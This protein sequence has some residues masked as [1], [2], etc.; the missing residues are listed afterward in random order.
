MRYEVITSPNNPRL[1]RA[2]SLREAKHR[3]REGLILIDGPGLIDRALMAGIDCQELYVNQNWVEGLDPHGL[4]R[5]QTWLDA[6]PDMHIV[7][8][9]PAAMAKLRYGDREDDAIAV[10]VPPDTSLSAASQRMDSERPQL[11]LVLDRMEKPGNLGAMVRSADASGATAV[12]I[13]DPICELWNPNAIRSSLGTLF[14]IPIAVGSESELFG[15]LKERDAT[16]YAARVDQG[17]PYTAVTYPASV[18]IVIGNEAAGLQERWHGPEVQNIFIPMHGQID[19]L[20]A[21]VCSAVMMFEVVR[22][23]GSP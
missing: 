20:N 3:K 13:S 23:N 6:S 14:T 21:S 17:T 8:L 2:M 7:A 4:E 10:A 12:F 1:K 9:G 15:W 16:I 5:I 11:F 18:A 22:Q 19:S